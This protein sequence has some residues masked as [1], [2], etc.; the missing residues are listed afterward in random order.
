[1]RRF[2]YPA[3]GISSVIVLNLKIIVEIASGFK[4]CPMSIP[5]LPAFLR[6][7]ENVDINFILVAKLHKM[8]MQ[9][10]FRSYRQTYYITAAI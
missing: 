10:T 1:M 9:S 4:L 8:L 7:Y 3:Q 2:I 5:H 6:K